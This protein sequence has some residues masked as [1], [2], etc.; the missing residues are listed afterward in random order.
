MVFNR[1][2]AHCRIES[3]EQYIVPHASHLPRPKAVPEEIKFDVRVLAFAVVV[4]AIDDPGCWKYDWVLEFDI[5]G[6]YRAFIAPTS[7]SAPVLR[8]GT[9]ALQFWLLGLLP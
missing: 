5:K 9:L 8:L 2:G 1:S 7:R 4:L 3:S 6:H